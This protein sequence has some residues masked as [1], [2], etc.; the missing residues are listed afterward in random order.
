[1][2]DPA[3]TKKLTFEQALEELEG[4][5]TDLERGDS[6]LEQALAR[7]ERGTALA[8]RCEDRL[9]EA[10]KKVAVLLEDGPNLVEVDMQ[11]GE[12]IEPT[13]AGA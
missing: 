3:P 9:N 13:G 1:M 8:R 7:F 12:P 5:V 11:T 6:S 4:I 2:S 10:E